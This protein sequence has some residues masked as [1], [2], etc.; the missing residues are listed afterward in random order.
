MKQIRAY[1]DNEVNAWM[2]TGSNKIFESEKAAE[3]DASR[4]ENAREKYY[5][6]QSSDIE[7]SY[8]DIYGRDIVTADDMPHGSPP[9]TYDEGSS[10]GRGFKDA[11]EDIW[12]DTSASR[13][14][15]ELVAMSETNN[16]IK[17]LLDRVRILSS[18][19][20]VRNTLTVLMNYPE[21]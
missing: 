1:Y 16:D 3:R 2:R 5:E 15:K 9:Y 19:V 6:N 10:A 18:D 12:D 14:L 7:L 8:E 20:K 11:Y 17:A 21:V 4:A 13:T